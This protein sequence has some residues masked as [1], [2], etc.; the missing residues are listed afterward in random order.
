M[1]LR[2]HCF[3]L[4]KELEY[5]ARKY[6]VQ[7]PTNPMAGYSFGYGSLN[8]TDYMCRSKW[9]ILVFQCMRSRSEEMCHKTEEEKFRQLIWSISLET[10]KFER[11]A[12]YMCHE[13][14]LRILNEHKSKCLARQEK[15]AEQCNVH[16]N[17]TIREVVAALQ[18]QS[19]RLSTSSNEYYGL[20]RNTLSHYECKQ[21]V[22]DKVHFFTF[23][24]DSMMFLCNKAN[25]TALKII[26]RRTVKS[27]LAKLE[28]LYAV[29]HTTCPPNA[30]R[31]VMN[32]F[33]E[34]LP[35][36]CTFNYEMR[37]QKHIDQE[38]TSRNLRERKEKEDL[39]TFQRDMGRRSSRAGAR[40]Q[41]NRS[42]SGSANGTASTSDSS[43]NPFGG[44]AQSRSVNLLFASFAWVQML[45]MCNR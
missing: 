4:E 3:N 10:R 5:C 16:R 41:V 31:L 11:A 7:I 27:L 23:Y 12:A 28:C 42:S 19:S 8:D 6:R 36:G 1:C 35:D 30:V 29:L 37:L 2:K 45:H 44:R 14:N 20:M 40:L 18:N 13:H 25:I 43:A 39:F 32:Y 17:D 9:H 26:T 15:V 22:I 24:L 34:T 21:V 38:I 33:K